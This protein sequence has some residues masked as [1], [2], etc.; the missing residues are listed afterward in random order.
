MLRLSA[1][2]PT[3]FHLRRSGKS[4]V[5]LM[6]STLVSLRR[7]QATSSPGS[8]GDSL[9]SGHQPCRQSAGTTG[10]APSMRSAGS[11]SIQTMQWNLLLDHR[12]TTASDLQ[13]SPETDVPR[14]GT[15]SR[16]PQ[17]GAA[18]RSRRC[19]DRVTR[20]PLRV[21]VVLSFSNASPPVRFWAVSEDSSLYIAS[22]RWTIVVICDW[23]RCEPNQPSR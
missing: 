9:P 4:N 22:G 21:M 19:D 18:P 7:L 15:A 10:T 14:T 12:T 1:R 23:T 20:R 5:D 13:A 17:W 2:Y 11:D 6:F 8:V 16:E 3:T